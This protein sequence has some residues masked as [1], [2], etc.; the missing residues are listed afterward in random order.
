MKNRES[1]SAQGGH[2]PQTPNMEVDVPVYLSRDDSK[3]R[4]T[5]QCIS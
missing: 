3:S 5:L 4:Y 2:G 1:P